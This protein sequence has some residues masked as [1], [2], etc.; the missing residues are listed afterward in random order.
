MKVA[1]FVVFAG[2]VFAAAS[3]GAAEIDLLVE[4]DAAPWSHA[5]GTGYTNDVVKAAFQAVGVEARLS[6]VPYARCRSFVVSGNAVGCFNMAWDAEFE[7]TVKFASVPLYANYADVFENKANPL[8]ARTAGELRK[9]AV[10]GIVNGYEYPDSI[11]ELK[12]RGVVLKP[13]RSEAVALKM[14]A[15]RRLEAAVVMTNDLEPVMKK[16]SEADGGNAIG[17]AFRSGELKVYIGFSTRHPQGAWALGKYDEGFRVIAADG[18]LDKI[19]AKWFPT[20]MA[21]N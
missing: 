4:D 14:L 5:D 20:G 3:A 18:T 8:K 21:R 9:G 12:A 10:V 13:L 15:S 7:G 17:Y 16:A 19:R 2:A 6:V 11:N 1:R